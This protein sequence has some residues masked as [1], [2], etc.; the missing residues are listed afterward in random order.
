M[1]GQN[2]QFS[3]FFLQLLLVYFVS[4]FT[5]KEFFITSR[6]FIKSDHTIALIISIIFFPGTLIHEISHLIAALALGLKVHDVKIF[7]RIHEKGIELGQV[8][9]ERKDPVRGI[10]AGIAPLFVGLLIFALLAYFSLFPAQSIFLNILLGY[11]IFTISTNM[12]SSK[13]DLVDFLYFLPFLLLT[14]AV[15]YIFDIKIDF[16]VQ[17][18]QA[19]G[20]LAQFFSSINYFLFVTL[21]INLFCILFLKVLQSLGRK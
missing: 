17:N 16:V 8:L 13:Q 5:I 11:L 20:R 3:L 14:I 6:R 21:L 7:P 15:F 1:T 19:L 18:T 12:F 2:I 10:I 9:Y 4:R